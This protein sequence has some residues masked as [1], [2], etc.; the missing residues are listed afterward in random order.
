[1][2]GLSMVVMARSTNNLL[3]IKILVR[4]SIILSYFMAF[5]FSQ[6]IF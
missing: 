6:T 1:M 2:A 4:F 5:A 3:K